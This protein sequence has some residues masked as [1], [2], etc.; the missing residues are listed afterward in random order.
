MVIISHPPH[1]LLFSGFGK[2][3]DSQGHVEEGDPLA[4][5]VTKD[6][7]AAVHEEFM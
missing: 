5:V 3:R 4:E 2:P 1:S 7:V 6:R